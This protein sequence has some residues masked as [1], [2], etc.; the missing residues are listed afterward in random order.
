MKLL[1]INAALLTGRLGTN[2]QCQSLDSEKNLETLSGSPL[3]V[4]F[5]SRVQGQYNLNPP[6]VVMFY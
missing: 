5:Y 2:L 3:L 6:N 1:E 4:S